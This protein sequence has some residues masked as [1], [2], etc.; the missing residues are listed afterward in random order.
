[1][2]FFIITYYFGPIFYIQI[3]HIF[4]LHVYIRGAS[5]SSLFLTRTDESRRIGGEA[6][7]GVDHKTGRA[8]TGRKS[9]G[10]ESSLHK[11]GN[12]WINFF[13]KRDLQ[14]KNYYF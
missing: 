3:N 1:M 7:S 2:A 9:R 8:G 10:G 12:F 5:Y 14:G 11:G 6:G 13:E 4:I